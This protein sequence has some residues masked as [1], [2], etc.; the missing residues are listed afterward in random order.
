MMRIAYSKV[1]K[2]TFFHKSLVLQ[3]LLVSL[4]S[5]SPLGLPLHMLRVITLE[6]IKSYLVAHPFAEGVWAGSRSPPDPSPTSAR[7]GIVVNA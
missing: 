7:L 5:R 3:R 1:Q 4:G 2:R 6:P